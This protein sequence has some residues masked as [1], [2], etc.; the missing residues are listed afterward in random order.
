LKKTASTRQ[1]IAQ[2]A[3]FRIFLDA[4][5]TRVLGTAIIGEGIEI[6]KVSE[7]GAVI[8]ELSALLDALHTADVRALVRCFVGANQAVIDLKR[9]LRVG[10]SRDEL[11]K[12]IEKTQGLIGG[13]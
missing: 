1:A 8:G 13:I 3:G 2:V 4:I 6:A 10:Q 12:T 5:S 9:Q 7:P 11:N